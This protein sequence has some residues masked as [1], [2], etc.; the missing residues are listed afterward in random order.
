MMFIVATNVIASQP[1]ERRPTVYNKLYNLYV[2][3][4]AYFIINHLENKPHIII[5]LLLLY[6]EKCHIRAQFVCVWGVIH[7]GNKKLCDSNCRLHWDQTW[8]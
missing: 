5:I 6:E 1:P 8:K 2:S 7:A 3:M 4:T